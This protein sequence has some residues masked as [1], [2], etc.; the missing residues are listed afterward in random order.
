M[1]KFFT[2]LLAMLMLC[3]AFVGCTPAQETEPSGTTTVPIVPTDPTDPTDPTEPTENLIQVSYQ[4]TFYIID[5]VKNEI[6][7]STQVVIEGLLNETGHLDGYM[8]VEA[9]PISREYMDGTVSKL[10]TKNMEIYS[11][12]QN[13]YFYP[14]V[15]GFY[16][17]SIAKEDPSL[18]L[19]TI[20]Y[21][22]EIY[23]AI[24]AESEEEVWD[25]YQ[26]Y[27]EI[28]RDDEM[29]ESE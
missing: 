29:L 21:G 10:E 11:C 20:V 17:I 6:L 28:F 24:C 15:E 4:K 26:A 8:N 13:D 25:N 18:A 9:Y 2:I 23:S 22:E 14:D 12:Q 1:E 16:I 7:G 5:S 19:A 27:F 3:A